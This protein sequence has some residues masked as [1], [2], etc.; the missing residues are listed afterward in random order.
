MSFQVGIGSLG[1]TLFFQVGL[2][3]PLQA[4]YSPV[5]LIFS[6]SI[7][8]SSLLPPSNLDEF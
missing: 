3:T 6:R 8:P 2:C 7:N 5:L 4:M 1:E